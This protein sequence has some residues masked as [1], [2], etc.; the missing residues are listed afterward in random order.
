MSPGD[1]ARRIHKPIDVIAP[2]VTR[3]DAVATTDPVFA[4]L[5]LGEDGRESGVRQL[6][7]LIE[8][9][10]YDDVMRAVEAVS[11]AVRRGD[12]HLASIAYA[13][14]LA[15][16]LVVRVHSALSRLADAAGEQFFDDEDG[17]DGDSGI[18]ARLH[19]APWS[20]RGPMAGRRPGASRPT[21]TV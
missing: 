16:D 4:R 5:A 18:L 15:E 9:R 17:E 11:A 2:L 14:G 10:G 8:E 20:P 13:Y 7:A 6:R 12:V 19:P 3:L 1:I 21:P